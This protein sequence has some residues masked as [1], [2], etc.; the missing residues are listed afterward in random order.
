MPSKLRCWPPAPSSLPTKLWTIW[1]QDLNKR[2][3]ITLFIPFY[4]TRAFGMSATT[5]QWSMCGTISTVS[6]KWEVDRRH[7][8]FR[9]PVRP[10]TSTLSWHDS[11][12]VPCTTCIPSHSPKMV[13]MMTVT[14]SEVTVFTP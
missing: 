3:P 14:V 2:E 8:T 7:Q 5:K 9:T 11:M 13:E 1:R 12:I 4:S 10:V 6:S